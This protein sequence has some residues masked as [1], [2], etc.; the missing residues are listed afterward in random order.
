MSY[1]FIRVTSIYPAYI[2]AFYEK[3]LN[4]NEMSYDEH[5]ETLAS[6]S[7]ELC[8]SFGKYL[9][10]LGVDASEIISND[11]TLLIKWAKENS[12]K[13]NSTIDDII[14]AQLKKSK[15]D[16]IWIDTTSYLNKKWVD[17]I[18]SELPSLK[19]IVAHICAPYN[20]V[21]TESFGSF[22]IVFTCS[23]CTLQELKQLGVNTYLLYHSFD[24]SVLEILKNEKNNFEE[25]DFTFTGSLLTGYGLH[26]TRIEYLEKLINIGVNIKLYG[27]I[28]SQ[29]T[30]RLKQGLH[31]TIK[32]LKRLGLEK[33]FQNNSILKKYSKYGDDEIVNYSKQLINSVSKPVFG[34][35]M[36]KALQK[37]KLCFNIHG[38]IAKKCGGNLRL[39]EATGVGTCL[40]TDFKDNLKDIFEVDKEIVTYN[41][42]DDCVEKVTWLLKNPMEIK[43]IAKAGQERVLRDHTVERRSTEINELFKNK[44]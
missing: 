2:Q 34:L 43:K 23:P 21:M 16:V 13:E 30:I 42:V 17:M 41:S 8:F 29:K 32:I 14:L 18:K 31:H 4:L 7:L 35:E 6:N 25:N 26:K 5:L 33:S 38:D 39:F 22:D 15:P 19:L 1:R 9:R 27:N 20:S 11:E 40:V 12:L 28:E 36:Y 10:K 37:A 24:H 3:Q 44:M